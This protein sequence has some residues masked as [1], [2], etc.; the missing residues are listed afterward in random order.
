MQLKNHITININNASKDIP[1]TLLCKRLYFAI[2]PQSDTPTLGTIHIQTVMSHSPNRQ[3]Y[4]SIGSN[5]GKVP[6]FK[7]TKQ[8]IKGLPKF[9]PY[10]I[11]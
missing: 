2:S 8:D 3:L 11:A 9:L 1:V 10:A 4:N 5:I 7:T 6:L